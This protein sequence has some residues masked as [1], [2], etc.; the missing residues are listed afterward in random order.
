[1]YERLCLP[2]ASSLALIEYPLPASLEGAIGR[3]YHFRVENEPPEV[4]LLDA[5][6]E[7]L[8]RAED[9]PAEL[10]QRT[11]RMVRDGLLAPG[12]AESGKVAA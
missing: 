9:V 10:A 12:A 6:G 2:G 3:I 7:A 4:A 1:M 5:I 11:Y 8:S